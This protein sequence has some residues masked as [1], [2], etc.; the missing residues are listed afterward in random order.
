MERIRQL[1]S[2]ASAALGR[3]SPRERGLVGLAG[4][5]VLVFVVAIFA[6]T[7]SRKVDQREAR[8]K[9][10]LQQLE[11][12]AKLTVGFR[13]QEAERTDLERRLRDNKVRLFTYL[14]ELSKK[15]GIAIGGMNDK[16]T[17]ALEGT[18]INEQS[19]EVTFTRI[20]L[21]KLVKFLTEVEA[22]QGLVKVTRLRV[23]P[24]NDEPV[25]DAWLTV[26]TY[27]LE[28]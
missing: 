24:R 28:T 12:V 27:T 6:L 3:L 4:G 16:G 18:K 2:D 8:I 22:G 15:D 21:D 13:A 26:T 9:L 23:T 19:V 14:D 7:V 1:I 5:A 20:P 11:E 25:L 10:K 17:Q